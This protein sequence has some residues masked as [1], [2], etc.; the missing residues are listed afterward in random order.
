LP[1]PSA[2]DDADSLPILRSPASVDAVR[3]DLTAAARHVLG[4]IRDHQARLEGDPVRAER[5]N[6][7]L[8]EALV[9]KYLVRVEKPLAFWPGVLPHL[10][11]FSRGYEIGV[12]PGYL[13]KL[14]ME[15]QSVQM[16]GCDCD[17]NRSVV[18]RELRRTLGIEDLV[19]VHPVRRR[20]PIPIPEG[21]QALLGFFTEF[22]YG[23]SLDDWRWFLDHCRERLTGPKLVY[24]LPNVKALKR[25]GVAEYFAR[26]GEHP[27]LRP[28]APAV[29]PPALRRLFCRIQLS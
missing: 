18:F 11:G 20:R 15:T 8:T 4:K 29:V 9:T 1:Q 12:G 28:G 6:R 16:R 14:L 26:L 3:A 24:L 23:Y 5:F 13:F 17:P 21:T 7:R 10:V 19:D 2:T 22:N 27:L 25:E